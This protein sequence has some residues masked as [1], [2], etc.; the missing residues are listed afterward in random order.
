MREW[1]RR[2]I[3]DLLAFSLLLPIAV[4]PSLIGWGTYELIV[5][6]GWVTHY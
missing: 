1:V 3:E 5:H 6:L 2:Y 4:A